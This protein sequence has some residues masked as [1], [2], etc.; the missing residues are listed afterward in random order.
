MPT[1]GTSQCLNKYFEQFSTF[2]TKC[3]T[4]YVKHLRTY[5]TITTCNNFA[6]R[7]VFLLCASILESSRSLESIQNLIRRCLPSLIHTAMNSK[8]S[9]HS[10]FK[11]RLHSIGIWYQNM[12]I[13]LTYHFNHV[14]V[15]RLN[16]IEASKFAIFAHSFDVSLG[17]PH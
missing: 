14:N 1:D 7:V 6:S 2:F 5:F 13:F 17:N 9:L 4:Y 15:K 11:C 3:S 12:V 8:L 10:K 16:D